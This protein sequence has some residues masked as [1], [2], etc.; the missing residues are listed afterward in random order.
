MTI[1]QSILPASD[2]FTAGSLEM[3]VAAPVVDAAPTLAWS[4][5]TV[6][7]TLVIAA[8]LL[9]LLNIRNFLHIFPSLLDCLSRWKGC[10]KI[11]ASIKLSHERN[12]TTLLCILP[13]CLMLDRY[14]IAKPSFIAAWP[15]VW[16]APAMIGFII[17]WILIRELCFGLCA[18]RAQR[19]ETFRST[20]TCAMD[21]F[22]PMTI[23]ML[24]FVGFFGLIGCKDGTARHILDYLCAFLYLVMLVRKSQILKSYCNPFKTFLYLCALEFVPTGILI[25]AVVLI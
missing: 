24:I 25:A 5:L 4:D 3:P 19:L 7:S 2:A 18:L 23:L 13:F 16:Q 14:D 22:I 8:T 9:F 21:F 15:D 6:N 12:V 11:D 1:L 20:R 10:I 17:A